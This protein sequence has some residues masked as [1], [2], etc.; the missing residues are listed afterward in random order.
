MRRK[1]LLAVLAKPGAYIEAVFDDGER[2]E[3]ICDHPSLRP[4]VRIP[5]NSLGRL[6][7]F[8]VDRLLDE[9]VIVQ[10]SYPQTGYRQFVLAAPLA[11]T[12]PSTISSP[13]G[14]APTR[15]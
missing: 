14:D 1:Q 10:S 12:K 13:G 8:T 7:G 6:R 5:P 15:P 11:A 4:C 2:A 3:H 9:G